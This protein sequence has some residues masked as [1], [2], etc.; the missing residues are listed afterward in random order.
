MNEERL[1]TKKCGAVPNW[2][3][4][5]TVNVGPGTGCRRWGAVES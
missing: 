4:A 5:P 2:K 3:V 1:I